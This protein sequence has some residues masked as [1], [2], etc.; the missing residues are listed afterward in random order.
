[1][2]EERVETEPADRARDLAEGFNVIVGEGCGGLLV[3]RTGRI[4]DEF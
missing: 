4:E 1:M 2:R 3:V